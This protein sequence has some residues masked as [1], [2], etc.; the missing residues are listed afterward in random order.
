MLALHDM[1]NQHLLNA[2][3]MAE[4]QS[5]DT[6]GFASTCRGEMATYYAYQQAEDSDSVAANLLGEIYRRGLKR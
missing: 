2:Y 5:A 3:Q 1:G 4:A 6:W